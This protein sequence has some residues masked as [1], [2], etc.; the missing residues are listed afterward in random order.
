MATVYEI[1]QGINQAAANGAWDGA[2]EESLQADGKARDAGL[3]RQDGHYINDRR[4]MDGFGVKFH[5][6]ILRVTYQS[7]IR[8]KE[9]QNNGFENDIESHLAE[10]VKFLKKEYKAITGDTLTLKKQGEAH[11]LVQRISNYRTDVQAHCDYR[12]GGLTDMEEVNK[13]TSEERLD[14]AVRDWLALGPKNKRPKN[15]TRKGK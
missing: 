2:H 3:K 8:I 14:Q 13:G 5:G 6:P 15:D 7:E 4:V 11:I 10:I 1:I 9:V 12:I